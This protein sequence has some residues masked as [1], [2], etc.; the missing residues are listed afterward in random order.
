MLC[1]CVLCQQE[2]ELSD[3]TVKEHL[4]SFGHMKKTLLADFIKHTDPG[5]K[6][7]HHVLRSLLDKCFEEGATFEVKGSQGKPLLITTIIK[8]HKEIKT[9]ADSVKRKHTHVFKDIVESQAES[10]CSKSNDSDIESVTK[11]IRTAEL[12]SLSKEQRE[13][14]QALAGV[15]CKKRIDALHVAMF[16]AE[17]NTG[18]ANV[19]NNLRPLLKKYDIKMESEKEIKSMEELYTVNYMSAMVSLSHKAA[20]HDKN[21]TK[22]GE[23]LARRTPVAYC[24]GQELLTKTLI[25]LKNTG[26]L[27]VGTDKTIHVKLF[28]DADTSSTKVAVNVLNQPSCN[29]S[30][31]HPM[32]VYTEAPDHRRN[33]EVI[34]KNIK[35]GTFLWTEYGKLCEEIDFVLACNVA[36]G[37][38]PNSYSSTTDFGAMILRIEQGNRVASK[39]NSGPL[40]SKYEQYLRGI[41]VTPEAYHGV[42][43]T[44]VR[45]GYL[46][47]A[48]HTQFWTDHFYK[49]EKIRPQDKLHFQQRL[50]ALDR[51]KSSYRDLLVLGGKSGKVKSPREIETL[52]KARDLFLAEYRKFGQS[53]SVKIHLLEDHFLEQIQLWGMFSGSFNEQGGESTHSLF[54]NHEHMTNHVRND[55]DRVVKKCELA[56]RKYLLKVKSKLCD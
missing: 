10:S 52:V 8:P 30:Y 24:D 28:V 20:A 31:A 17:S 34:F 7:F 29:S 47:K 2:N 22:S 21:E 38:L 51:I 54:K 43:L 45:A 56:T 27:D 6:L 42:S 18:T 1:P 35:V 9:P 14:V 5:D 41:N 49:N 4:L 16:K 40:S 33:M 44:G 53:T 32:L 50:L 13:Y 15:D 46:V 48:N 39:C 25:T 55:E 37:F 36:D 3:R 23:L 19:R 26:Q 12:T 11:R